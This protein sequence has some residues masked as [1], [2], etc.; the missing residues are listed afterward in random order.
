MSHPVV[1]KK[2]EQLDRE[3]FVEYISGEFDRLT[4]RITSRRRSAGLPQI[5]I[6][7]AILLQDNLLSLEFTSDGAQHVLEIPC[8][9]TDENGNTVIGDPTRR[10]VGTWFLVDPIAG[11]PS[12]REVSYWELIAF[13]LTENAEHHFGHMPGITK[14]IQFERILRSFEYKNTPVT[15]RNTQRVINSVVNDLPVCGTPL[16]VWAMNRRVVFIDPAFEDLSPKESLDY[17][18]QKNR[19]FF[20][21]SSIGLSDTAASKN[22]LLKEDLRALSPFAIR[23]HNPMRNLYQTLGMTGEELPLVQT[24]SARKLETSGRVRK[25]YNWMTCFLETPLNFQDQLILSD[26]LQNHVHSVSKEFLAFGDVLVKEGDEVEYGSVLSR[27]PGNQVLAYHVHGDGARVTSIT[28]ETAQFNNLQMQVHRIAVET[29][30][31]FKDGSKFTNL[32]GNKGVAVFAKTGT[33]FDP[34]RNRSVDIDIIVSSATIKSRRNFGQVLEA[35]TTLITGPERRLVLKDDYYVSMSALKREL[36]KAGARED[37]TCEVNTKWGKFNTVCGWVFW[38]LI[39]DP[40]D[41]LWTRGDVLKRSNVGLRTSGV[42]LSHVELRALSTNLGVQ[43]NLIKE[44]LSHQEGA[45]IIGEYMTLVRSS[46]GEVRAETPVVDIMDLKPVDQTTSVFH[47]KEELL[48]TLSEE[49]SYEEGLYLKLPFYFET[50]VPKSKASLISE[51]IVLNPVDEEYDGRVYRTNLI[52]VPSSDLREPWQHQSGLWGLSDLAGLVNNLLVAIHEEQ[53]ETYLSNFN[54]VL[55]QYFSSAAAKLTTKWGL[56]ACQGMSVRYPLAS[57]ATAALS[58]TLPKDTIQIHTSMANVLGVSTGDVVLVERF[59]CLGFMSLRA[60][61][62]QITDEESCRYVVRVS[63]N[64]LNSLDLDFDGDVLFIMAFKEKASRDELEML[65]RYPPAEVGKYI[66]ESCDRIVPGINQLT[67][68]DVI[69]YSL[70]NGQPALTFAPL[71]AQ[72]SSQI[73]RVLIGIKTGTGTSVALGY[74]VLRL[75]EGVCGL[76]DQDRLAQSELI[77]VKV[78]NSVFAGKHRIKALLESA[79][80]QGLEA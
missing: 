2:E 43:S 44:V 6:D 31:T 40:E 11:M 32:H 56:L 57:K 33:M 9:R 18:E 5:G 21:W 61:R 24:A 71:T 55:K 63:G 65:L 39:K 7:L 15:L 34:V 38:G 8:P 26:K 69:S 59:P 60:Q 75:V 67:L 4:T 77:L 12:G 27:E 19:E 79:Q 62:V 10:A 13:L 14:R 50:R 54:R 73:A 41:A 78:A 25:G 28:E 74:N 64:S 68:D 37:G 53:G 22:Y 47:T 16:Q 35:L 70:D 20:P 51:R 30:R 45:D 1:D 58:E 76:Y 42:K 72:T 80:H 66:K 23:H 36:A 48:G 3:R 49:G 17:Q 46:R 29:K 52:Y